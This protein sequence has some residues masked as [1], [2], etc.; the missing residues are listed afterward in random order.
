MTPILH[1]TSIDALAQR[2]I[3]RGVGLDRKQVSRPGAK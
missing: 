3:E 1:P 2:A